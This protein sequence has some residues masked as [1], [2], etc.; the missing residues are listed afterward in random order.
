MTAYGQREK[1]YLENLYHEIEPGYYDRVYRRGRGTQWFWHHHRFRTVEELLPKPCDRILDLGCGPGTF[2]GN[3]RIPFRYGLGLDLA[4]AQIEFAQRTYSRPNLEFR[5]EDVRGFAL[6]EPFD[7]VVS[8]EVIEHLPPAETQ[9]F[10]RAVHDVLSPGGYIILTTPN[11]RS[12]W[13]LL[14]RLVSRNGPVDYTR[15]HI[16]PF[17]ISRLEKEA[18]E[19][20]F[21]DIRSQTFFVL[22]PFTAAL[23]SSLGSAVLRAERTLLPRLGSELALCARKPPLGRVSRLQERGNGGNGGDAS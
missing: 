7:A 23:S 11:Y 10:L 3:L 18:A 20:G 13:P 12:L 22:A 6:D 1:P 14:E 9:S 21:C 2:L 17:D 15:Q 5:A 8:I 4:T 16:N 19:A